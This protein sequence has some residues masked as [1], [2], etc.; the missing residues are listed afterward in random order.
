MLK[1][2][3]MKEYDEKRKDTGFFLELYKAV[4]KD[5]TKDQEEIV[6]K[7]KDDP[8]ALFTFTYNL[9]CYEEKLKIEEKYPGKDAHESK[10]MKD[11]GNKAYK[12]GKDLQALTF[13]TQVGK[14]DES[15]EV[16]YFAIVSGYNICSSQ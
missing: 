8:A 5:M 6:E 14:T 15:I 4:C 7:I 16:S 9:K 10:K 12:D 2:E 1:K 13:Y 3:N 11:A